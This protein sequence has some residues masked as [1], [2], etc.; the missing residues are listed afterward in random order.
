[1]IALGK[2]SDRF[3]ERKKYTFIPVIIGAIAVGLSIFAQSNI[4]M[5]V[6]L[7]SIAII[8]SDMAYAKFWPL[9]TIF[10]SLTSFAVS[11]E[12]IGTV[13]NFGGFL[14]PILTGYLRSTKGSFAGSDIALALLFVA[15][16]SLIVTL[17]RTTVAKMANHL[18][19]KV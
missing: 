9:P 7:I 14:G 11:I 17:R 5:I 3:D 18:P 2:S 8:A 15:A 13:G 12:V 16:A 6:V 1:M 4:A 19:G 10:L